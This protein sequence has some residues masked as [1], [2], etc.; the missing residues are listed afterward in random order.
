MFTFQGRGARRRGGAS[1]DAFRPA[2][3][4]SNSWRSSARATKFPFKDAGCGEWRRHQAKALS[5]IV[6]QSETVRWT[7]GASVMSGT[8]ARALDLVAGIVGALLERVFAGF[9]QTSGAAG[10]NGIVRRFTRANDVFGPGLDR[11]C[12]ITGRPEGAAGPPTTV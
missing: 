8:S 2:Q 1:G 9:S 6:A 7:I 12:E 10:G 4:S 5:Q 3:R 11:L